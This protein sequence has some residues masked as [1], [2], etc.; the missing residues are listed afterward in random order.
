MPNLK[1]T[2]D[3]VRGNSMNSDS[4]P[5]HLCE[6]SHRGC[7]KVFRTDSVPD[8]AKRIS[9]HW[10]SE[11]GQELK[12]NYDA[13]DSEYRGGDRIKDNIYQVRKHSYYVTAYDVLSV[14]RQQPI[15]E[16]FATPNDNRCCVSCWKYTGTSAV[17]A[18]EVEE[19]VWGCEYKCADCKTEEE[20]EEALENNQTLTEFTD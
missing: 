10:N 13:F 7:K 9:R 19:G 20:V 8:L 14:G 1:P 17:D 18:T 15:S 11:H 4:D 6:C 2:R 5:E 12:H 3:E 16:E